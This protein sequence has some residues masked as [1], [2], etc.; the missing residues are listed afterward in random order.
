[1]FDKAYFKEMMQES[2]NRA[3]KKREEVGRLLA[4]SRSDTLMLLQEPNLEA[5]PGLKEALDGFIGTDVGGLKDFL[6]RSDFS[7]DDYRN[8]ILST[9]GKGSI[10][11]SDIPPLIGESRRDRIWRFITLVFLQQDREVS[12]TQYG[13][14]ILV[15]RV[16][17]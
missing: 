14:D 16:Q 5:I 9:M 8:H 13:A 7:M 3:R 10:L 1:L 6:S 17:N 15:E 2:R 12:L 4:E 11:F